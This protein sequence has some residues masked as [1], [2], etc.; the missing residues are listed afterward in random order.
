MTQ[1]LEV[2]HIKFEI[3]T[4]KVVN[5]HKRLKYSNLAYITL[6]TTFIP[7]DLRKLGNIITA[8]NLPKI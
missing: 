4:L 1:G 3:F 2:C 5:K 8:D 7:K 6:S